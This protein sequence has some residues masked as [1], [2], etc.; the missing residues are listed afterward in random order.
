MAWKVELKENKF[1]Q[2]DYYGDITSQDL[3]DAFFN[4]IEIGKET[5]IIRCMVNCRPMTGGHSNFDLLF[6]IEMYEKN[7]IP[8]TMKGAVIFPL[9]NP[10]DEKVKFYQTACLNRGYNVRIFNIY[11]DAYDWL[12]NNHDEF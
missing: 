3:V 1:I 6:L 10:D 2:V 9:L 7:N 11:E 8:R 4:I 5:G 12:V